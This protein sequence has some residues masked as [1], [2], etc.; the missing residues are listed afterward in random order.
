MPGY[1]IWKVVI[2]HTNA[3]T[4]CFVRGALARF[5]RYR[6]KIQPY[7][8]GQ[9]HPIRGICKS[10]WLQGNLCQQLFLRDYFN[11]DK[12]RLGWRKVIG[13]GRIC[14]SILVV[15]KVGNLTQFQ[16]L[17]ILEKKIMSLFIS[18]QTQLRLQIS[19][20]QGFQTC[21]LMKSP[22]RS[23]DLL[24]LSPGTQLKLACPEPQELLRHITE[25][26]AWGRS[27]QT[28]LFTC[29][30]LPNNKRNHGKEVLE[31]LEPSSQDIG[32]LGWA[33]S[34]GLC[35]CLCLSS[36]KEHLQ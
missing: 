13:L 32:E 35:S 33:Q 28:M 26:R 30:K 5:C 8:T 29:M 16:S 27:D 4:Q 23:W 15:R 14:F 21:Q 1:I 12:D 20:A 22:E 31:M 25:G 2:A 10:G 34:H 19:S 17:P 36:G 18:L 9:K 24:S 3:K 6:S 7:K 11:V